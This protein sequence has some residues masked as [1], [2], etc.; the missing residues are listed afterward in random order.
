MQMHPGVAILGVGNS[1]VVGTGVIDGGRERVPAKSTLTRTEA[2][3]AMELKR[4]HAYEVNPQ[5]LA[6]QPVAPKGGAYNAPHDFILALEDYL[7]AANLVAQPP[8][9][10]RTYFDD[11]AEQASNDVR[12]RIMD[13][14]FGAPATAKSGALFLADRLSRA[15]DSRS[16][17]CLLV[18][19]AYANDDDRRFIGWAFPK[20]EPFGFTANGD[21]ADIQI[22]KNAFSRSSSYRKAVMFKGPRHDDHY[23][24]GNV[25][26]KQATVANYWVTTFLDCNFLI[27]SKTGTQMLARLL[28][29][30]HESLSN[31]SD[32]DQIT[33]AVLG[34]RGSQRKNWSLRRFANDF[35]AGNVKSTFLGKAPPEAAS[36]EFELDRPELEARVSLRVFRLQDDVVVMAPFDAINNSVRI[37]GTDERR[38]K[39]EGIVVDESVRSKRAR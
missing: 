8:V 19:T 24:N 28:K 33:A 29:E 18:L 14:T 6:G 10:F 11:D 9:A 39:C 20:D 25:I 37:S 5:R 12:H 26:D 32:K 17:S 36:T 2:H 31:R 27:D 23:W 3:I 7:R 38:L 22:I 30:T 13:Y 1:N 35:L 21:R 16:E 4:I 34:V 15:M